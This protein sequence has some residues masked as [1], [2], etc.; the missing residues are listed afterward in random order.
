MSIEYCMD[1]DSARNYL[2]LGRNARDHYHNTQVVHPTVSEKV[3]VYFEG[4]IG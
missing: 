4:S 3:V 2:V 1:F